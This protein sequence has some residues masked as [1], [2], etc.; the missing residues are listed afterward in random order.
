NGD[1]KNENGGNGNG[2]NGN[3][4]GNGRGD[5]PVTRECVTPRPK[6]VE[7]LQI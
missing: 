7:V 2:R 4:D 1:G 5:R 3:P 6:R